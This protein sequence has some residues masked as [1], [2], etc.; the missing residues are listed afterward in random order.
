METTNIDKY[1]LPI[2]QDEEPKAIVVLTGTLEEFEQFVQKTNRTLK[3]AIAVRQPY[4]LP[5]YP[6]LE[7]V[8]YGQFWLNSAYDSP[9]YR[10][11]IAKVT[12]QQANNL[13]NNVKEDDSN[14]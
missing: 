8:L 12:L 14:A 5:H 6:D 10:D 1:I 4:Q 2:E 7:I 13:M 3:S 11:R 9:E